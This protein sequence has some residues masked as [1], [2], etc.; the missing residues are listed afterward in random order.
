VLQ[1]GLLHPRQKIRLR[2]QQPLSLDIYVGVVKN[3]R[4]RRF[5]VRLGYRLIPGIF[6]RKNLGSR[7]G[8][9]IVLPP[10]MATPRLEAQLEAKLEK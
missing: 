8:V 6:Q 4:Q 10:G 5:H 9:G 1:A 2:H 3:L 7:S